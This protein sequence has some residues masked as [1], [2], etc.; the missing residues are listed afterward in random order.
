MDYVR[1]NV[2]YKIVKY[3]NLKTIILFNVENNI[4]IL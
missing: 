4:V 3:N 1:N 2:I